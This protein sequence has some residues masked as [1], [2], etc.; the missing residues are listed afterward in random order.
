MIEL[1]DKDGITAIIILAVF[2]RVQESL[3]I[4]RNMGDMKQTQVELLKIKYIKSD[5]KNTLMELRV[6]QTQ[7]K[8][9]LVN[10]KTQ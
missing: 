9:K 1:A 5:K 7:Q 8:T 3:S 2:N 10:L 6:N 4:R